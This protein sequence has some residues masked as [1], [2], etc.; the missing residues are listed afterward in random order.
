MLNRTRM[1]MK[2]PR[3]PQQIIDAQV[4]AWSLEQRRPSGSRAAHHPIITVSRAFGAQGDTLGRMLGELTGFDV[5]DRDLVNAVADAAGGDVR[6][7]ESLDERRRRAIDDAVRGFL[8]GIDHTNTQYFRALARV[9]RTICEHG[10]AVVVGRGANY[11]VSADRA[12]RLRVTAPLAW[13]VD[14]YAERVGITR[15]KAR[16]TVRERDAERA[17]FVS[18]FFKRDIADPTEY[19]LVLNAASLSPNAMAKMAI[20]AY[21]VRFGLH[22]AH[23]TA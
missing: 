12:L 13:R 1:A 5:W 21:E 9:I 6:I 10:R 14:A 18:H 4:H 15:A 11:F 19:D 2:A 8:S 20:D 16:E 17:D 7:M 23:E 3:S 22:V